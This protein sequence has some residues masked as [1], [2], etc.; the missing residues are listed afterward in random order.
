MHAGRGACQASSAVVLAMLEVVL[1][2]LEGMLAM[3]EGVLAMLEGVLA[4]LEDRQKGEIQ[5]ER[6][7]ETTR[8]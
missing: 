5:R 6:E 7:R 3:L 4:M 8:D 1:V 2:M